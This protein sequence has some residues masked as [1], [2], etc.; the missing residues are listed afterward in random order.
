LI[1]SAHSGGAPD[2]PENAAATVCLFMT[3]LA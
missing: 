2:I 1:P 3:F